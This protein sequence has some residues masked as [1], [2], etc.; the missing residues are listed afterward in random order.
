M[1]ENDIIYILKHQKILENDCLY[2]DRLFLEQILAVSGRKFREVK[3]E[4]IRW[5]PYKLMNL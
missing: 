4:K 1:G 3:I 5:E 2:C